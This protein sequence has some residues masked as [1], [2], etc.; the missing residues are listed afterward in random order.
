M[1]H[2]QTH[3]LKSHTAVHALTPVDLTGCVPSSRPFVWQPLNVLTLFM[4]NSNGP[5]LH[6]PTAQKISA[7]ETRGVFR[8]EQDPPSSLRKNLHEDAL[9]TLT[10]MCTLMSD[11]NAHFVAAHCSAGSMLKGPSGQC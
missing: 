9:E 4:P 8:T 3:A 5:D 10:R 7:T 1:V 11:V 2:L 6:E